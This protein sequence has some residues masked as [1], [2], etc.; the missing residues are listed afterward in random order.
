MPRSMSPKNQITKTNKKHVKEPCLWTRPD[1]NSWNIIRMSFSSSGMIGESFSPAFVVLSQCPGA[2]DGKDSACSVRDPGSIPGSGRSSREGNGNPL[3]YSC[4]GN[5]IDRGAWWVTV[6]GIPK[7][8]TQLSDEHFHFHLPVN[9][10]LMKLETIWTKGKN[11]GFWHQTTCL[12]LIIDF[13]QSLKYLS[14]HFLIC[15]WG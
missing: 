13:A 9:M 11:L 1:P 5:L 10:L 15:K 7:S 3:Q 12:L 8:W 14:L 4:L 6:H 2:L